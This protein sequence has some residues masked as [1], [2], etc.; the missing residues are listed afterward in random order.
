MFLMVQKIVF[1][2]LFLLISDSFI[3]AQSAD[4]WNKKGIDLYNNGKYDE[5][6][7]CHIKA[8]DKDPES[9]KL[10]LNLGNDY[11]KLENYEK[12][13]DC[14]NKALKYNPKA[15]KIFNNKGFCF[16]K[17]GK[18]EAAI[19]CFDK[20]LQENPDDKKAKEGIEEAKKAQKDL[21]NNY[22]IRVYIDYRELYLPVPPVQ[23]SSDILI[24]LDSISGVLEFV[25]TWDASTKTF[26][27]S[28]GNIK[29]LLIPDSSTAY[30]NG[31]TKHL[32][33]PVTQVYGHIMV[34]LRFICEICG[35]KV[36]W[37]E[38][39][40]SIFIDTQCIAKNTEAELPD[41]KKEFNSPS[42]TSVQNGQKIAFPVE[43]KG[44]TKPYVTVEI[45]YEYQTNLSNLL[46]KGV[47]GDR[48][49]V[50]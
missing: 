19:E 21:N 14:Y 3:L 17:L 50:V 18:Y 22:V 24:C 35:A 43:I 34:P 36:K 7:E 11:Y 49:S 2:L 13:L 44:Y 40:K 29:L 38:I 15:Y 12:A 42:I 25:K 39:T 37:D 28:K 47:A 31:Q 16:N 30:L 9:D 41:V 45:T 23:K 46:L 48:K 10:W 4:D 27:L 5:A 26:T 8:L 6:L 1:I 33:V 32:D 20:V